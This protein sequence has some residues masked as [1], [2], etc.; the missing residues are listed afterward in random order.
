MSFADGLK[1]LNEAANNRQE[2]IP[3][4]KCRVLRSDLQELL[5]Y[6]YKLDDERRVKSKVAAGFDQYQHLAERTANC[7]EIDSEFR[8]YANFG[9]GLAGEA[10]E[11]CDYLKKVVFHNHSLDKDKLLEELGD[12]LWYIATLA[13]TAN[14]SLSEVA[15]ANI[16]KLR[17]RYPNGFEADRSINREYEYNG[18][19]D[20]TTM[21]DAARGKRHYVLPQSEKVREVDHAKLE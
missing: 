18:E 6:F 17:N 15:A 2:G 20:I 19:I 5:Y 14:L 9:M 12:C 1:R 3:K 21:R 8:R 10:G 16:A 13:T 7:S 4:D 11:T